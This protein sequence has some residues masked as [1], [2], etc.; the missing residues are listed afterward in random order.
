MLK[1]PFRQFDRRQQFRIALSLLF[2]SIGGIFLYLKI[3]PGGHIVYSRSWPR[4]LASGQGFFLD[5]KP[6]ERLDISDP[7]RLKMIGDPLYF[8]LATPRQFDQATVTIRYHGDLS[9]KT[10]IIEVGVLKDKLTGGYDLQPLENKLLDNLP[11]GWTKLSDGN[12]SLYQQAG[13]YSSVAEF[14][15]DLEK[16]A[17][18][19]CPG[20]IISCLAVYNYPHAASYQLPEGGTVRPF[21]MAQ[22]LRG[23][24]SFFVYLPAGDW[25]FNFE[26]A[27]LNLDPASDPVIVNVSSPEKS[28]VTRTLADSNLNSVSGQSEKKSLSIEGSGP[29]GVYK[30]E[31]RASDDIVISSFRSPSDRLVFINKVWPVSSQGAVHFFTDSSYVQIKTFNPA[32]LGN[33]TLDGASIDVNEIYRQFGLQAAGGGEIRLSHDDVILENSGVFALDQAGLFNP[34]LRRIDRFFKANGSV[35][36]ILAQYRTPKASEGAK[37]ATACVNLSGA[38]R[39]DGKYSWLIS[40]PGLGAETPGSWLEV[41]SIKVELSGKTLWQKICSWIGK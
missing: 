38:H 35:R 31:V 3:V 23:T 41:E 1:N 33:V 5:F 40:V 9:L 25:G 29:A 20:G 30:V 8:S 22:P 18:R 10:P 26:L 16:R 13:A 2:L 7:D 34:A 17:V 27:D 36:Y 21:E 24:H 4:G 12:V 15:A 39:E 28:V 19:G 37:E 14:L 32:S 6:G 11:D